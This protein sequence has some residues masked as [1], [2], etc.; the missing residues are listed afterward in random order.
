[1]AT[2]AIGL[3]FQLQF[4]EAVFHIAPEHVE[5]VINELGVAHQVGAH[6]TL[7]GAQMG[8]ST[9]AMMRRG[10]SQDSAW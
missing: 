10:W 2:Q 3:E 8:V 7:I 5:V 6:K 1:V 4:L 9:L